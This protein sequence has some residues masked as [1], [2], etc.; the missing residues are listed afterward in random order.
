MSDMESNAQRLLNKV[1]E[2]LVEFNIPHAIQYEANVVAFLNQCPDDRILKDATVSWDGEIDFDFKWDTER[3]DC[4]F[5]IGLTDT[6]W[7]LWAG[8]NNHSK[9]DECF[10]HG[11][12]GMEIE[13]NEDFFAHDFF[14]SMEWE[15]RD[16]DK[17]K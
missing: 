6:G 17:M 5:S 11:I 2:Q 15:M 13:G 16:Y 9:D 14:E 8:V 10:Q 7:H 3:F 12:G 1:K 4:R